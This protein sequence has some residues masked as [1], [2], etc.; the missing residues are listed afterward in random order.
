MTTFIPFL[1]TYAAISE[2]EDPRGKTV[3]PREEGDESQNDM[4]ESPRPRLGS[5]LRTQRTL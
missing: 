3:T 1:L 2:G 5:S 4:W